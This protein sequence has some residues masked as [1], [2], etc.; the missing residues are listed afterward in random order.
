MIAFSLAL[1]QNMLRARDMDGSMLVLI[2]SL[3]LSL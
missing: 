2:I 1:D 3:G